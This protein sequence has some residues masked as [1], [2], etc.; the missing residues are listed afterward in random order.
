MNSNR[1]CVSADALGV[2]AD[3]CCKNSNRA[4]VCSDVT[5]DS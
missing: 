2:V 4:R 5:A 3:G 1:A